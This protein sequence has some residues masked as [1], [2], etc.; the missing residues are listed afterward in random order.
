MRFSLK[1]FKFLRIVSIITILSG[2]I[3]GLWLGS[4]DLILN[5]PISP[6]H[7]DGSDNNFIDVSTDSR[8]EDNNSAILYAVGAIAICCAIIICWYYFAG[9]GGSDAPTTYM[10]AGVS[11]APNLITLPASEI[12]A[13]LEA[14]SR[15]DAIIAE[16]VSNLNT[17]AGDKT[18]TPI[19]LNSCL[20]SP[21]PSI[22]SPSPSEISDFIV[23][24]D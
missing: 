8:E 3:L 24:S 2:L 22:S 12:E 18:P 21:A 1:F 5:L 17:I 14:T 9:G 13:I 16:H 10:E 20:N 23:N 19:C 15:Q 4:C 6:V 7:A 11:P